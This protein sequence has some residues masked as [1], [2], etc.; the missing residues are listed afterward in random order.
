MFS[1]FVFM[2]PTQQQCRKKK[3]PL[4]LRAYFYEIGG[5]RESVRKWIRGHPKKPR[6][7]SILA[8]AQSIRFIRQRTCTNHGPR[9]LQ[10]IRTDV[11]EPYRFVRLFGSLVNGGVFFLI[12]CAWTPVSVH[13]SK[14]SQKRR[15]VF[16]RKYLDVFSG[17]Y[18]K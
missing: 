7:L 13:R 6:N 2:H 11:Q 1:L 12:K 15:N 3:I 16:L 9:N 14:I 5:A 17:T 4:C 18:I 8:P 10:I